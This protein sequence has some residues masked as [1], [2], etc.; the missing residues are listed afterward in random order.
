MMVQSRAGN[1][2]QRPR[3]VSWK[4]QIGYEQ[5]LCEESSATVGQAGEISIPTVSSWGGG[6]LYAR[7]EVG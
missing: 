7:L 2:L 5:C 3:I 4:F 6:L 1:E